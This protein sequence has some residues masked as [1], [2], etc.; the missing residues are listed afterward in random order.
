MSK[1]KQ[2]GSETEFVCE[3]EECLWDG[4]NDAR[5]EFEVIGLNEDFD[6][7]CGECFDRFYPDVRIRKEIKKLQAENKKLRECVEYISEMDCH[8][9]E[10]EASKEAKQ[11]LE[12]LD[13]EDTKI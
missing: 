4:S 7:L 8:V 9:A 13:G 10:C 11:C 2:L 1:Y 5:A 3:N 6:F 12:E